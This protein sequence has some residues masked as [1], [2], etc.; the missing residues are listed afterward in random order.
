MTITIKKSTDVVEEILTRIETLQLH[1]Q[2]IQ[3][4]HRCVQDLK[5]RQFNINDGN[6]L[7]SLIELELDEWRNLFLW[8]L[9]VDKATQDRIKA[10]G[11]QKF[12]GH[13]KAVEHYFNNGC[14]PSKWLVA[15]EEEFRAMCKKEFSP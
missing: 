5:Y 10:I 4:A 11:Y 1:Q 12:L 3:S 15:D 8:G 14:Q 9:T 7:Q 13:N 6:L 2:A